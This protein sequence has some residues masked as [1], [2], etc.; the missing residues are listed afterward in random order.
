MLR[1][2]FSEIG[3]SS[4]ELV[5]IISIQSSFIDYNNDVKWLNK[6]T[7]QLYSV[8]DEPTK[9]NAAG[10]IPNNKKNKVLITVD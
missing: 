9:C 6:N 3:S 8:R 7:T 10:K 4:E 5:F 1:L 2:R